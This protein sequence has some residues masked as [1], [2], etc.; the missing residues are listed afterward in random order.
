MRF[1]RKQLRALSWYAESDAYNGIVC[2]GAVRSGKTTACALGF[3]LWAMCRFDRREF[4]ICGKSR[5]AVRRN[6]VEPLLPLLRRFGFRVSVRLGDACLTVSMGRRVN[7]FRL[8]GGMNEASAALIQGITLAGVLFDE[9]TLMPE[10]F[11]SQ[12]MAR[13]SVD[14]AKLWYCCNPDSP[15]HWFKR[16][17]IDRAA[18]RRLLVLHFEMRDNPSLSRATLDMYYRMFEGK[19]FRRYVLGLWESPEG[20]VYDFMEDGSLASEPPP[21]PLERYAISVDYGTA[22]PSSFGLW[23]QKDGVWWRMREFYHDGRL[24]GSL[25][26]EEYAD[27]L[28]ALADGR[29]IAAV[30][31]DPSAR[32]F[33][34]V[35]KRR[36]YRV[37]AAD[38]S[39]ADGIRRTAAALKSGRVR[40]S[41]VCREAW[42]EFALYRWKDGAGDEVIKAND[43]A[44]DE[45]RYFVTAIGS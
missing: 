33:I 10:S 5:D 38:N 12:A 2:H 23:G 6:L 35:L 19:F 24:N 7:T 9:V 31:V 43:H 15:A 29:R 16:G 26:D 37:R 36:G 32:S 8:F 13:C 25:T 41:P 20:L 21:E 3:V 30:I 4:A 18:E 28:D 39:V 40:I 22:N 11:V 45:I 42:R 1:S 17:Y 27:R 44:M 14:G 34:T